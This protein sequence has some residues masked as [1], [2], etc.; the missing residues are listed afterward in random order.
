MLARRCRSHQN[1]RRQER[2]ARLHHGQKSARLPDSVAFRVTSSRAF[3]ASGPA[4]ARAVR[5]ELEDLPIV[6]GVARPRGQ[7]RSVRVA[8]LG[9]VDPVALRHAGDRQILRRRRT[10][11]ATATACRT[12]R[13]SRRRAASPRATVPASTLARTRTGRD[14]RVIPWRRT[15]PPRSARARPGR[16]RRWPAATSVARSVVP[17]GS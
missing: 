2:A 11:A 16:S 7:T 3:R 17:S 10:A 8:G 5:P 15:R 6:G 4:P 9:E 1:Q 14:R 12:R 13:R